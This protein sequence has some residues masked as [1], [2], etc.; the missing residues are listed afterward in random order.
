MYVNAAVIEQYFRSS[1]MLVSLSVLLLVVDR[2]VR[3]DSLQK[4]VEDSLRQREKL[5]LQETQ[6]H[7]RYERVSPS[8]RS[9]ASSGYERVSH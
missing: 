4:H 3:I 9:T 6:L 1:L 8:L 2:N 7:E 5:Q